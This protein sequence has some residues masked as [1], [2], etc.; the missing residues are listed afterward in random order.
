MRMKHYR[1]GA[2][3]A[4]VLVAAS[5][6]GC[7]L[8]PTGDAFRAGAVDVV[9]RAADGGVR[10]A[11]DYL[12]E[13]A[14]IGSLKRAFSSAELVGAYNEF[15]DGTS[16]RLAILSAAEPS[17]PASALPPEAGPDPPEAPAAPLR[18]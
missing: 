10:N 14:T 16:P 15:C 3:L 7:G 8:T 9:Q 2:V 13:A 6:T 1:A 5:L 18:W 12:C 11:R 17:A 4:A